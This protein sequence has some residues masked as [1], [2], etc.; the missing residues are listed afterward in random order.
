MSAA[1]A[2]GKPSRSAPNT[3][4]SIVPS[5]ETRKIATLATQNTGQGEAGRA[6]GSATAGAA[7]G[8]RVAGIMD[9][10]GRD[11]CGSGGLWQ[12]A[13]PRRGEALLDEAGAFVG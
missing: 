12:V 6:G 7:A 11:R 4:Y 10:S 5:S 13:R 9:G 3:E 1:L 8:A 2:P